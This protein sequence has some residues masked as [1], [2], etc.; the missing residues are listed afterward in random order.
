[1]KKGELEVTLNYEELAKMFEKCEQHCLMCQ[2]MMGRL[3][4]RIEDAGIDAVW[5]GKER[6]F[7]EERRNE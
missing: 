3:K 4:R 7:R 2:A 6:R 5:D 1:M